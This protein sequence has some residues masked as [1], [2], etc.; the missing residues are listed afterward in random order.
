MVL[1]RACARQLARTLPN[2]AVF[3]AHLKDVQKLTSPWTICAISYAMAQRKACLKSIQMFNLAYP[4]DEKGESQVSREIW[5]AF[6]S[7]IDDGKHTVAKSTVA[8]R[9]DGRVANVYQSIRV[10]RCVLRKEL[11]C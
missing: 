4:V 2:G 1:D 6:R 9:R 5:F 11:L 8:E 3:L 7:D 10:V